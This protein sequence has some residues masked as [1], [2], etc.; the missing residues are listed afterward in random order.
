MVKRVYLPDLTVEQ[1]LNSRLNYIKYGGRSQRVTQLKG[2]ELA[3]LETPAVCAGVTV[4]EQLKR[5][6]HDFDRNSANRIHFFWNTKYRSIVLDNIRTNDGQRTLRET[7]L[8]PHLSVLELKRKRTREKNRAYRAKV[9]KFNEALGEYDTNA[10]RPCG[11]INP[12]EQ[13]QPPARQLRFIYEDWSAEPPRCALVPPVV[14]EQQVSL[15]RYKDM[16]RN[17]QPLNLRMFNPTSSDADEDA[18]DDEETPDDFPG[19]HSRTNSVA[20]TSTTVSELEPASLTDSPPSDNA[21][22]TPC[23]LLPSSPYMLSCKASM[24][25]EDVQD[26]VEALESLRQ[27]RC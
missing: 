16:V 25:A 15:A 7:L 18:T 9:R 3:Q 23:A 22:L 21:P 20:S 11:V 12:V 2:E 17:F 27:G 26:V 19:L 6:A 24:L 10:K 4:D 8:L 1:V 5:C 13:Q 14:Q